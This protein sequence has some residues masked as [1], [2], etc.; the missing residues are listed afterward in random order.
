MRLAMWTYPWD[1]LDLGIEA[2]GADLAG[3]AR[4]NTI[5]LAT[6]YHAG[7]FLQ[8]RSPARHSYFP[9]DGT[10]YFRPDPK[11]WAD[12]TL[13]PRV[14]G[15]IEERG[16]VL[17]A[18]LAACERSGLAVSCWTVLLHNMR[19]G[20]AHP[21]AAVR[22]VFGDALPFALCPSNE[23][24][25]AYARTLIADL[26]HRYRPDAVELE[27]V[28]F[29]G[30]AHGYHH[31]KDGVGLAP[32]DDFLLAL[33]FCPSCLARAARAGVDGRAAGRSA[34]KLLNA[35]L[36]REL[37]A[38]LWPDFGARGPTAFAAH[39]ALMEYVL[40]RFEPVTSLVAE[41]RESAH[42]ATR[43]LVIEGDDGW[44]L[45]SDLPALAEA[46]DGILLCVYDRSAEAVGHAV[47]QARAAIGPE[48]F[49]GAGL[50]VFHPEMAGP[51]DLAA[52]AQAAAAS[53][54][55]GINFYNY[56]LIPAARLDW[57]RAAVAAV[58]VLAR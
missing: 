28:G 21:E 37:P 23:A 54:A 42:P 33:C 53:G 3:R 49:L 51:A 39:P 55:E 30:Y 56:G 4:L 25:R 29:M 9:E 20:L 17:G 45:G 15:L 32:E 16:D 8:P 34:H 52:H 18:L 35:A 27:T 50:R 10:I 46:A 6:A 1:V 58:R 11:A 26:T 47:A 14:A 57:V 48:R 19:L 41:I 24:V 44:L 22:N 31:E 40:W 7:R 43:I 2:V 5:S 13:T 36:A 12:R 38:P